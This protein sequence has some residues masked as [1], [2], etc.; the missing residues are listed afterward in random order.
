MFGTWFVI[1]FCVVPDVWFV[2]P[3]LLFDGAL[4]VVTGEFVRTGAGGVL[5]VVGGTDGPVTVTGGVDGF[6]TVTGGTRTFVASKL[7]L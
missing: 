1:G 2:V 3:L 6:V 4:V 5:V 7:L